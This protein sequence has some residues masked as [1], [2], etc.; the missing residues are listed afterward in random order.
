[1]DRLEGDT[2]V[3]FPCPSLPICRMSEHGSQVKSKQKKDLGTLSR[4]NIRKGVGMSIEVTGGKPDGWW[5]TLVLV[6]VLSR[7]S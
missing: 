3:G 4:R 2:S 1:M 6:T 5:G 7:A